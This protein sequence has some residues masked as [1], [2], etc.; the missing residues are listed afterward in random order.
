MASPAQSAEEIARGRYDFSPTA[1][2]KLFYVD[3][4]KG[5]RRNSNNPGGTTVHN[6][7]FIISAEWYSAAAAGFPYK[8]TQD[9]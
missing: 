1:P 5:R 7:S 6:K 3:E 4:K 9:P 2:H 8:S